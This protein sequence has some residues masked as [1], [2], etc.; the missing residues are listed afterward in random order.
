MA[1]EQTKSDSSAILD[2][3]KTAP[4]DTQEIVTRDQK[5]QLAAITADVVMG[6]PETGDEDIVGSFIVWLEEKASADN[7]DSMA[8]LAQSLRQAQTATEIAAVVRE[9]NTISGRDV[10]D[11][12]FFALGFT[13]HEG[14]FE[15]SD[16][17]YFAS[18]EAKFPEID[19]TVIVNVGGSKLL[20]ALQ[21][22]DRIGQ[23]PIPLVIVGRQTRKGYTV[24]GFKY[25]GE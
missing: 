18:I 16:I 25:L 21:A 1:K 22:F 10:I 20:V 8:I 13:V 11:R 17:P 23:W 2:S 3:M 7:V 9:K 14:T 4:A 19:E 24:Q 15:D 5:A 6:V 12:P